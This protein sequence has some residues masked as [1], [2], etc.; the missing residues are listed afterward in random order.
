MRRALVLIAMLLCVL[1]A[2]ALSFPTPSATLTR[3]E[4]SAIS[5]R[6]VTFLFEL[7][8]KNPYPVPLSF[9]GMNLGFKVEGAQVFTAQSQGGFSVPGNGTKSNTFNVTLAYDAVIK[10]VKDYVSR[11][12]LNIVIDGTLVIPLPRLPGCPAPTPSPILCRRRSPPS[13]RRSPCWIF[14]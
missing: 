10:M 1:P 3:F 6:D 4:V 7:T 11:D 8:V 12:F 5:L 2:G 13:S 9:S 14:R